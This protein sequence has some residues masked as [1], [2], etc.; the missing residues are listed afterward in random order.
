MKFQVYNLDGVLNINGKIAGEYEGGLEK[1]P[2][3][4]A[5]LFEKVSQLKMLAIQIDSGNGTVSAV[6]KRV[7]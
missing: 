2:P 1:L 5:A 7:E 6:Y 4:V 3:E